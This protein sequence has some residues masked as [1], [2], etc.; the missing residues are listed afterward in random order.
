MSAS[1]R[2]TAYSASINETASPHFRLSSDKFHFASISKSESAYAQQYYF[3]RS[4]TDRISSTMSETP[5]SMYMDELIKNPPPEYFSTNAFQ[6]SSY[7]SEKC[8]DWIDTIGPESAKAI[9]TLRVVIDACYEIPRPPTSLPEGM[10][11]ND[12]IFKTIALAKSM[13]EDKP[14]GPSWCDFF[15]KV[16]QDLT[17]LKSLEVIWDCAYDCNPFGGGTDVT[18]PRAIGKIKG[19]EL[20][21]MGGCYAKE[22]PGYLAE[23]TGARIVEKQHTIF[24][25]KHRYMGHFRKHQQRNPDYTL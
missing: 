12:E 2:E 3:F 13:F 7:H 15:N 10:S 4:Q 6:A 22:W 20:L 8:I 17:G 25:D 18:L 11:P 24:E 14:S 21:K 23:K 1:Q 16:A 19:L 5:M 9:G